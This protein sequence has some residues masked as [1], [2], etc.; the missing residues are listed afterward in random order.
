[1]F[2]PYFKSGGGDEDMGD[3]YSPHVG[4]SM[5]SAC[6]STNGFFIHSFQRM[7]FYTYHQSLLR[8]PATAAPPLQPTTNTPGGIDREGDGTVG[9]TEDSIFSRRTEAEAAA[10]WSE[11]SNNI[12]PAAPTSMAVVASSAGEE[13]GGN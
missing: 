2:P 7:L 11:T 9:A 1:M 10:A 12:G 6:E 13:E 4:T 8:W 5:G 3:A